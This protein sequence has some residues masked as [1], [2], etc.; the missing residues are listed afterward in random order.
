[1]DRAKRR[2]KSATIILSSTKFK[3]DVASSITPHKCSLKYHPYSYFS[4][5]PARKV[6]G[7]IFDASGKAKKVITGTW[8]NHLD[9]SDVTKIKD[10]KKEDYVTTSA[11]RLWKKVNLPRQ[12]VIKAY[13]RTLFRKAQKRCITSA[14]LPYHLTKWKR[15]SLPLI[16]GYGKISN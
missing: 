1:M 11:T 12:K 15:E 4:R 6:T 14:S 7:T 3:Y 16:R 10:A 5:E 13:L 9:I 8:D 2:S